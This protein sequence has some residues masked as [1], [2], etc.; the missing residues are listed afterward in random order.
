MT[1][2]EINIFWFT[3]APTYYGMMYA[4]W[5]LAW[6]Y[7][8][9]K[10]NIIKKEELENLFFYVFVWVILGG[11]LWYVLFYDLSSYIASP[12][13]IVK[14]WEWW[15]SFHGGFLWVVLA[16]VLFCKKYKIH[17][18]K[19]IDELAVIV[20]VWIWLGRIGN[21]LNKE[22]LWFA[23]YTWMF[24]VEKNG[25]FYFPSPLLEAFLEWGLLLIFLYFI[26]KNKTFF[27]QTSAYFLIFYGSFRTIVELFFRTPDSH[28]WY[29]LWF[30]T[31]GSL[32]S[33]P[34]II[35]WIILLFILRKNVTHHK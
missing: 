22:L 8:I 32:L 6:Y 5:F 24:A 2:F 23:N 20:P 13:S 10:K 11:R 27:W 35:V 14:V 34:M 18:W 26:N 30:L 21:Y 1:I 19:L 3:L 15:M 4:L 33:I 29:I 12:L 25:V 9:L 17:F 16:V 31:L 7:Y 28:I